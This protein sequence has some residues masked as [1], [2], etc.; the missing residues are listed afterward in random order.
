MK[1]TATITRR[2][3]VPVAVNLV[4]LLTGSLV[5]QTADRVANTVV[6]PLPAI[7]VTNIANEEFLV[8]KGGKKVLSDAL[9][10]SGYGVFLTPPSDVPP[11]R[12]GGTTGK[13][14]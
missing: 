10:D 6:N 8:E 7:S 2:I 5:A 11:R 12:V 3:T 1:H 9:F 14:P 4:L 13:N